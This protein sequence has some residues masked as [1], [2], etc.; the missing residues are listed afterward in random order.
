MQD[1]LIKQLRAT[2]VDY[3]EE[4]AWHRFL[5][6]TIC[7]TGGYRGRVGPAPISLLG[8][9]AEAYSQLTTA[10]L[11]SGQRSKDQVSYLDQFP[12]EDAE[13]F[14][15][16]INVS[17]FVNYTASILETL[18]AYINDETMT[19]EALPPAVETWMLDVDGHGQD[20]DL[21]MVEV[22][23]MRAAGLGWCPVLLDKPATP[24]G[25][26]AGEMSEARAKEFGLGTVRVMPLYPM[27]LLDWDKDDAGEITAAKTWWVRTRTNLMG[28]LTTE[29]IFTLWF[30]DRCVRY[31]VTKGPNNQDIV[32]EPV[33]TNYDYGAVPIK[34]FRAKP[35]TE[36]KVRGSSVIGDV[37]TEN[38][39]IFNLDSELDDFLRNSCFPI[40]GIPVGNTAEG[41][42][43]EIVTGNGS[44][45]AIPM[46]SKLPLHFVAPPESVP[47]AMEKRRESAM[48]ELYRVAR[49]EFQKPT[50]VTTSGIARAYEFEQTNRRLGEIAK[51]FARGEEELLTLAAKMLGVDGTKLTVSSPADFSVEDMAVDLA[52]ITGIIGLNVGATAERELKGRLVRRVLPNLPA[53]TMATIDEELDEL[54][55][56]S[57]QDSAMEREVNQAVA[58]EQIENP[59]GAPGEEFA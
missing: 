51:S 55:K 59:G 44:A 40:L 28:A 58:Q 53:A 45:M 32:G 34:I 17:H 38:R 49:L 35:A 41:T 57:E 50:G 7:G 30:A 39:R 13:K 43:G 47:A 36:D 33:T 22:V 46:E 56:Q 52:N 5:L 37:A 4:C 20:W 6:D 19:R 54:A 3:D 8:W 18:M 9:A 24:E 27:N 29:E 14:R 21:L 1:S 48:R 42:M 25:Y 2:R 11:L 23:R 15:D 10:Q 26:D 31:V 16:R 12:R